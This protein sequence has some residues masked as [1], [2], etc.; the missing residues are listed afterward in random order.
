MVSRRCPERPADGPDVNPCRAGEGPWGLGGACV[1]M[2]PR[3]ESVFN[4]PVQL[5]LPPQEVPSHPR[6]RPPPSPSSYAPP[7][8][9]RSSIS[10]LLLLGGFYF[11]TFAG[12]R[13]CVTCFCFFF[14]QSLSPGLGKL[15]SPHGTVSTHLA[16]RFCLKIFCSRDPNPQNG[17]TELGT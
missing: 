12:F 6:P 14:P 10:S 5:C 17:D 15:P 16:P 7:C 13:K 2:S 1:S 9:C 3:R 8:L 4:P 11:E